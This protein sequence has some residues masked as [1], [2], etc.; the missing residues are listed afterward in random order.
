MGA[1][2]VALSSNRV[3]LDSR[4][5]SIIH[6]CGGETTFTGVAGAPGE[7]IFFGLFFPL[8]FYGW[9]PNTQAVG[10]VNADLSTLPIVPTIANY[11]LVS[12]QPA[13]QGQAFKTY[14]ADLANAGGPLASLTASVGTLDPF[15]I[16]IAPGLDTLSFAP[17]PA[18]TQITSSTTFTILVDPTVPVDFSKLQ[19][20]FQ[21]TAAPPVPIIA[22]IGTVPGTDVVFPGTQVQ[23]DGLGS[24]NPSGVG[25]L[26]YR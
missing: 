3:G 24:M 20:T 10:V 12:V 1:S 2:L 16:R 4:R 8:D 9:A 5:L 25:T 14:G 7:E 22:V 17:V 18:C 19:W 11:Q 26:T 13:A 6:Y 15:K 21:Q 23:L